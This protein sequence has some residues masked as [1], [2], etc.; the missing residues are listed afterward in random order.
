MLLL[1]RIG[2]FR[3]A[4]PIFAFDLIRTARRR[5]YLTIRLLYPLLVFLLLLIVF[6]ISFN[7]ELTSQKSS[8]DFC[9]T[10]FCVF[11][12]FN[13]LAIFLLTPAYAAGAL[14]EEKKRQ[15]LDALLASDL[16]DHEIVLGTYF[17]RITKLGLIFLSPL[18][19]FSFLQ[20]LGGME[21]LLIVAGFA[22]TTISLCSLAAV[23]VFFSVRASNPREAL[24]RTYSAIVVLILT[25]TAFWS[26]IQSVPGWRYFPGSDSALSI[27]NLDDVANWLNFGNPIVLAIQLIR[28][29]YTGLTLDKL[30][31][32]FLGSYA[33][34]HAA[35]IFCSLA[36]AAC[37]LRQFALGGGD[38]VNGQAGEGIIKPWLR[39]RWCG[40]PWL[41]NRPMLWKELL[42]E[43]TPRRGWA[44]RLFVG[45]GLVG[46]LF[47][48]L[49]L[50]YFFR[51]SV[52]PLHYVRHVELLS[53]WLRL[54]CGLF[55]VIALLQTL[56][57]AT[58]GIAGERDKQTFEE[59][60]ATPLTNRAIF[61]AKWQGALCRSSSAWKALVG[62]WCVGLWTGSI[63]PLAIAIF[64]L[65][66]LAYAAFLSSVG[67][68]FS[69][70]CQ[71]TRLATAAA[72]L[73]LSVVVGCT[74]LCAYNLSERYLPTYEAVG[75]IPIVTLLY[76]TFTPV[77]WS[78]WLLGEINFR[79]GVYLAGLAFWCISAWGLYLA[80]RSRFVVLTG[81]IEGD[82]ESTSP[83]S[84]DKATISSWQRAPHARWFTW[85]GAARLG[86]WAAG[87]AFSLLPV[88]ALLGWYEMH[89]RRAEESVRGYLAN[90]DQTDPGWREYAPTRSRN[91]TTVWSPI[92]RSVQPKL[93]PLF[94]SKWL[95]SEFE[96]VLRA[97]YQDQEQHPADAIRAI[98]DHYQSARKVIEELRKLGSATRAEKPAPDEDPVSIGDG[99][100]WL[101]DRLLVTDA[102]QQILDGRYHDAL[103]SCTAI[104]ALAQAR[105]KKSDRSFIAFGWSEQNFSVNTVMRLLGRILAQGEL[106]DEDMK[107]IQL[108][109]TEEDRSSLRKRLHLER[110]RL[111]WLLDNQTGNPE[112]VPKPFIHQDDDWSEKK[113]TGI[114]R[115]P[116]LEELLFFTTFDS[117]DTQRCAIF[118]MLTDC[119]E[120]TSTALSAPPPWG[121]GVRYRSQLDYY[122]AR[123]QQSALYYATLLCQSRATI[124]A[125]ALE[126][127]R[128]A[129]GSWPPTLDQLKP[130]YL[131]S[132]PVGQFDGKPLIYKRVKD[133][134]VV[135]AVGADRI[136]R[137]GN[138]TRTRWFLGRTDIGVQLW[139]PAARKQPPG[140]IAK[141]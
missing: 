67:V 141:P 135:Y 11:M 30:L 56:A 50:N 96:T 87:T 114:P 68:W 93:D 100:W 64:L 98:R 31:P 89:A 86:T 2:W 46:L 37:F 117:L 134:V 90:L 19:I 84:S 92:L 102:Y 28:G 16:R 116:F 77:E 113:Y 66:W 70:V 24:V 21:P 3:L 35:V 5:S 15:T 94:E 69:V 44:R 62:L 48:V 27:V 52:F 41:A 103:E 22:F 105:R 39:K 13:I 136:D 43:R 91:I 76:V 138:F 97:E 6:A 119:I 38:A 14:A 82:L 131:E 47:P 115:I 127:Y 121:W 137:G 75:L 60:L 83:A 95:S 80:A 34:F 71:T 110:A 104:L 49:H 106:N 109:L 12:L 126:R 124:V 120:G 139:D 57:A 32:T 108:Q 111:R 73:T 130:Y 99:E 1:A 4:G 59:L 118:Q 140:E 7:P 85:T 81:R 51:G 101:L 26:V 65:C 8:A 42:V 112:R 133:G 20:F 107:R 122:L 132:I 58:G 53:L 29:I 128:L 72:F 45:L 123:M 23:S 61:F 129:H 55:G 36:Y 79:P 88:L 74:L 54:L 40:L 10:F 18:P 125:L 33:A 17:S 78:H 63:H 9:V 25:G